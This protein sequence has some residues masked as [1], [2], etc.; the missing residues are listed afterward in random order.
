MHRFHESLPGYA[1]TELYSLPSLSE[2]LGVHSLYVKDESTRFGLNAFK[3]LGGSYSIARLLGQIANIPSDQLSFERLQK[4]DVK[5]LEV[6]TATDGNH[7]RGIAWACR[8]FGIKAHVFMPK[9]SS[10]ER[11]ANIQALGADAQI[12]NLNYDDCV[13]YAAKCAKEKGWKLVQDT[14]WD[15][16][17]TIPSWIMQGYTTMGLEIV[18]N[19]TEIP[20]HIF[21]QAGVGAMSG[22]LTAFFTDYYQYRKPKIIIVEPN[23]ANCIFQT[24]NED[25]GKLHTVKD[26]DT[27]MAGLSCGEPCTI[28][29]NQLSKCA[30]C[31]IS[32][33]D[34]IAAKGMRI[35]GNP[36]GSDSRIISGESGAVSIG[37]V[38]QIMTSSNLNEL[39]KKLDLGKD[40]KILCISTEGDTDKES[41]RNIVWNGTYPNIY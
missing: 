34:F 22:A 9:G 8:Q 15:G 38:A 13:R 14:A 5:D 11:L 19:L 23:G 1:A 36:V 10:T 39:R 26:L 2:Y 30:D 40:S 12:T 41:Y 28:G 16:Y 4:E 18:E 35:L 20:T 29:W 31:F 33:P 6:V 17:E 37:L 3:V 27:I 32:V 24:A 7:G 21:L 25:D